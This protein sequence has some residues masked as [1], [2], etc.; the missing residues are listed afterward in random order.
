MFPTLIQLASVRFRGRVDDFVSSHVSVLGESF[1]ADITVVGTFACVPPLVRLE[2]AELAE[3]LAA[4]GLF[5]EKGFDA[6]VDAGVD[7]EV[8][9]LTE[10]FIAPRGGAFVLLFG[11]CSAW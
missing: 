9:L 4:V 8:G 7:V 10:G 2:V 6:G 3:A 5:A 1:A 11:T